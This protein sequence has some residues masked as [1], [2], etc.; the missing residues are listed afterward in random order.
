MSAPRSQGLL[1]PPNARS[2]AGI[3]VNDRVLI[4]TQDE[5]R[6]IT[7]DG[8]P[9]HHYAISDRMAE[10]Y[11][12]V[13]LVDCGY[14]DQND[15]ARAF[16]STARTLRRHQE[17]FQAG[18]LESLGRPRGR[19]RSGQG[20]SKAGGARDRTILGM[21]AKDLSNRQIGHKL[22]ISETAVRKRLRRL[23]FKPG[24]RQG[25]LFE[26]QDASASSEPE[27]ASTA[28]EDEPV[29]ASKA[30]E[31]AE[32]DDAPPFSIDTDPLN[33]ALDRVCAAL[34]L[35]DDAMPMFASAGSVPRGGVL[36]AIPAIAQS[37]VLAAARQVYGHIGPAFYGLRTTIITLILL[38]LLRI[39]RPEAV[40]EHSP[41]D[42][43][44]VLGLDRAPEVKTLRRKL[45]RL[46]L[47]P[48]AERLGRELA[49]RRI[50]TR[51]RAMGFLYLDGHVRV[52]HGKQPLSKAHVTRMRIAMPA[53]TDYWVNDKKGEPLFV[54]TAEANAGMT[55]MLPFVL[56]EVR[57]LLGPG[58]R[59][60]IVFDRG[61]WSPKLF[62][63]L[64]ED[65]FDILTYR[66]GKTKKVPE[67]RFILR[68]AKLD[69]RPVSYLLHDQRVRLLE[70]KL[71]LRQVT[72]L[73]ENGHQTPI[74]TNRFD[75]RDV[76]VA[77][78]MFDRWRQENFF[79][80]MRDEYALDAL[81]DHGAEPA[82]TDRD[83]P[84]PAWRRANA[85]LAAA[86]AALAKH[87]ASLGK[88]AMDNKVGQ[89]S[90]MRGFK[91]TQSKLGK[92]IRAARALVSELVRKRDA[93][94]R[95]VPVYKALQGKPVVKLATERKH[96][97]NVL[98]MVAYQVES[99][100]RETLRPHYARSEDE[101]RTLVQTALQTSA[102]IEPTKNELRI[103]LAPLSSMHR[104]RAIAAVC[105]ELNATNTVFPGTRLRLR[106]GVAGCTT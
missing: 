52:Y 57:A 97:M 64:I 45:T 8:M 55:Q 67:K 28:H 2:S 10:A 13:L 4:R 103:T 89:R 85:K 83:V 41:S 33:R 56:A 40:K 92:E 36:L 102:A 20:N 9:L 1:F 106:Y 61:G 78:H 54:V 35:L 27:A 50:A 100:I 65:G 7:V 72:R 94:P 47:L 42:L 104:S 14:A 87:M 99:D 73:T 81:V 105:A 62:L 32:D 101:G 39:K 96:L 80:Y 63:K 12:M 16:G 88:A 37:G 53:T 18:G 93:L 23:G 98:K 6:V 86:R 49:K 75:L 5:I 3:V 68:K 31:G 58:R 51:G 43:G 17:R 84:N 30:E 48:R 70:G 34:G 90:T 59:A 95:R 44:R 25:L 76:V 15:V 69:G 21:K 91:I 11:A 60:T 46:A 24:S 66:K 77:H 71:Q 79:K 82:D 22:G 19:P 38:A 74:L 26:D 29:P